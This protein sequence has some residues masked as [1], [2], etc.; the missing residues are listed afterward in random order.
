MVGEIFSFLGAEWGELVDIT[1]RTKERKDLSEAWLKV[2]LH[3][4]V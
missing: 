4:S 1:L 2:D 3:E